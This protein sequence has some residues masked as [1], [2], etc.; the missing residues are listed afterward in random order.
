MMFMDDYRCKVGV[1]FLGGC[2]NNNLRLTMN[3]YNPQSYPD[4]FLFGANTDTKAHRLHFGNKEEPNQKAWE[5]AGALTHHRL[6]GD[7]VTGGR[8]AGANPAVGRRAAES[9]ESMSAMG[10]FI[11]SVDVVIIVGAAGGGTGT[12]AIPVAAR[13]ATEKGKKPLVLVV[14]PDPKEGRNKRATDALKEIQGIAP[15]IPIRNSYLTEYMAGMSEKK[16]ASLT[17]EGAWQTVNDNSLVPMLRILREIL[18][19][20]GDIVNLDQ[21]DWETILSHGNHVFFGLVKSSRSKINKMSAQE[22]A[23]ELFTARFQ[24]SG[25]IENAEVACLWVHGPWSMDKTNE[26]MSLVRS[27]ISA[28]Q[29]GRHGELEIHRGIV[30]KVEDKEMWMAL[31]VVAKDISVGEASPEIMGQPEVAH[32]AATPA[33]EVLQSSVPTLEKQT[34][35]QLR[36]RSEGRMVYP[37][38]SP[39]LAARYYAVNR[40][41]HATREDFV[42]VFQEVE[43]ATTYMPDMPQRFVEKPEE[44]KNG[45]FSSARSFVSPHH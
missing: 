6:G 34:V 7:E 44:K 3:Q 18:Q 45:F 17:W 39:D 36:F 28:S 23:D 4:F 24:D 20:T 21:A 13:L 29:A 26:V 27:R 32:I 1:M 25:V 40:N 38:V 31:L 12:G 35:T 5:D 10:R 33:E 22:I 11:D 30:H 19:V 2:G 16:R 15:T 42:V 8:G 37:M 9:E 41:L 43:K 14:M